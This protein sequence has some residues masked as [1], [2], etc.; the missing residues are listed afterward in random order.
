MATDKTALPRQTFPAF[1][2]F[3]VVSSSNWTTLRLWV[4]AGKIL[5]FEGELVM[6][7]TTPVFEEVVLCCEINS[8]V[9]AK[10]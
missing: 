8:Y 1:A 4:G 6:A 3:A 9:S 5:S 10:L 7:W 2:T